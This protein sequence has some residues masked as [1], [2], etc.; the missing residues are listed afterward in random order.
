MSNKHEYAQV[1]DGEYTDDVKGSSDVPL[2]EES[3]GLLLKN[4]KGPSRVRSVL[5]TVAVSLTIF[6]SGLVVGTS[7]PRPIKEM[8]IAHLRPH[9]TTVYTAT[10]LING[11]DTEGFQCGSTWEEAKAMG[12][13]FDVMSSRW[14]SPE[15][16]FQEVLDGFMAEPWVNFTW[17]YDEDHTE[18][19]PSDKAMAGEFVHVYPD[20][21]ELS[22]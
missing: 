18:V 14:Y 1:S 20:N 21:S 13:K 12:C 15:C 2:L 6:I 3:E 17:Y 5:V 9:P 11:V 10:E 19:F 16:F 7:I 8:V 4:I 22:L